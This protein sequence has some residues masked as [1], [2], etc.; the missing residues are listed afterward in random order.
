MKSIPPFIVVVVTLLT[1]P[2]VHS[3]PVEIEVFTNA[4]Y[5]ISGLDVTKAQDTPVTVY[6]LDA[7]TRLAK[8]LGA[9][10][11]G[12]LD[13]A[14]A[15]L[16]QRIDAIGMESLKHQFQTAARGPLKAIEYQLTHYPAIVFDRG[17]MVVYGVSD[18]SEALA[19]YRRSQRDPHD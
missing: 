10:L 12:R 17:R 15:I 11:P 8:Q 6:D 2:S 18:L 14:K 19:R 4:R 16:R 9:G 1:V 13:Q 3:E 7:P 5:P